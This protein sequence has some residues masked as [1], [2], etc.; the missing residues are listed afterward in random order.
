MLSNNHLT[1]EEL[2]ICAD[3]INNERYDSLPEHIRQHLANCSDCANELMIISEIALAVEEDLSETKNTYIHRPDEKEMAYAPEKTLEQLFQNMQGQYRSESI[4]IKTPHTLQIKKSTTDILRWLNPKKEKLI[5]EIFNNKAEEIM[6][7]ET[8]AESI[9][10]PEL[11]EGLY[12]W[13]LISKD[14]DLLFAGKIMV[15]E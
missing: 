8:N 1:D 9:N 13:K 14:F 7:K 15:V 10:I 6:E 11:S 2:A 4:V 5:V 3:A 12:Y